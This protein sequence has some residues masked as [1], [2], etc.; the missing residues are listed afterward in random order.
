MTL[1]VSV[2]PTSSAVSGDLIVTSKETLTIEAGSTEST[3]AV[4]ITAV[5]T[6]ADA[7]DETSPSRRPSAVTE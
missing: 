2:T 1:I 7:P 3:D 4:T 6:D 5:D